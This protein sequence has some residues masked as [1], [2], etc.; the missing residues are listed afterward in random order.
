[1]QQLIDSWQ[2]GDLY[3]QFM[4]RWSKVIAQVFLQ[5]LPVS[6]DKRWLDVGC[7]TGA[8][9]RLVLGKKQAKEVLAID[10]SPEFIAFARKIDRDPRL[11]FGVALAQSVPAQSQYFDAVVSGLV[12]N[13]VPRPE[14]AVAERVRVT[15]PGGIV[16][17]YVWDYAEG[18]QMLRYFWDA[19]VALDA[20]AGELDEGVRFPFSHEDRL[21]AL[22]VDSGL[23][24]VTSRAV[25]APT[26]FSSF[27]DYWRPFFSGVGP[28][29]GYLVK[30]NGRQ[31]TALRERLELSLPRSE[32]GAISLMAR[33]WAVR[34]MVTRDS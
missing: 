8:L 7:G 9:S 11:H 19:A 33:A 2:G 16:T 24:A 23:E 28:A 27:E 4:G 6:E 20:S 31:Q 3:E 34:G 13:F 18:M 1:M 30:L 5:W 14:Q 17:A 15:K 10:A 29:P 21:K 25:E 22:F 32:S 26:I 12:L